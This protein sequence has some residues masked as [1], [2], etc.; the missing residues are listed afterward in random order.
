MRDEIYVIAQG[1]GVFNCDG[2]KTSFEKDDVFFVP[3]GTEHR[4]EDF[5]DDFFTCVFFYGY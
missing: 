2:E 4:F 1:K 3:K 5:T